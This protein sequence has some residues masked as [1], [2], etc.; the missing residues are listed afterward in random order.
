MIRH[1]PPA[2]TPG[3]YDPPA[4]NK[5]ARAG[6]M[7][8]RSR[9]GSISGRLRSASDL[10]DEGVITDDEKGLMKVRH[11]P[12]P[13]CATSPHTP[14]PITAATSPLPL[15]PTA[16]HAVRRLTCVPCRPL[17]SPVARRRT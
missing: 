9:A 6:S 14:L 17:W 10:F 4:F 1:T 8:G 3:S 11:A 13:R 12:I 5:R 7:G 2:F 16:Y 15:T